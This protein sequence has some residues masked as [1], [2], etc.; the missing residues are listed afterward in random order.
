MSR[1]ERHATN[2][3]MLNFTERERKT[4]YERKNVEFHRAG[5]KDSHAM[6]ATLEERG[7][8]VGGS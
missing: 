3:K 5:E 1:S 6:D 8:R 2:E 4:R 7:G